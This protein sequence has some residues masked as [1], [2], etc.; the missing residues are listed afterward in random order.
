MKLEDDI[1]LFSVTE[2]YDLMKTF[3]EDVYSQ[4]MTQIKLKEKYGSSLKLIKKGRRNIII[5]DTFQDVLCDNWYRARE[6]NPEEEKI[7]IVTTAAKLL[8]N[9]IKNY[10]H[11]CDYYPS[12]EDVIDEDNSSIPSLLKTFIEELVPNPATKKYQFHKFR[13]VQSNLVQ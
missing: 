3:G 8:R 6:S 1:E 12:V 5:L 13:L 11:D 7:R 10:S 2:F 9:S 4:K